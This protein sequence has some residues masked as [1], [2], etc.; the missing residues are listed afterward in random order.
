MLEQATCEISDI[1]QLDGNTSLSSQ[2]EESVFDSNDV[3]NVRNGECSNQIPVIISSREGLVNNV[4]TRLPV[5][6]RIKR[7]NKLL[8]ATK[9]PSVMNLNPRSIYNKIEEFLLLVEQYGSD[10]I[11]LSETWDRVSQPLQSLIQIENYEV[12]T[13]VNP[14]SFRG[15]QPALVINNEKFHIEN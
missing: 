11:F 13:S 2:S 1:N 6:R 4:E 15:G 8:E 12:I 9:L 10:L 7:S 14:R 3:N 5:L